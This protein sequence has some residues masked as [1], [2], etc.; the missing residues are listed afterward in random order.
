MSKDQYPSKQQESEQ[1]ETERHQREARESKVSYLVLQRLTKPKDF[2]GIISHEVGLGR[3]RVNIILSRKN[4]RSH[5]TIEHFVGGSF[6][7][8]SDSEEIWA[9]NPEI[10]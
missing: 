4:D 3:Y 10:K 1:D 8:E 9:S 5:S 7:V 2:H 6:Y